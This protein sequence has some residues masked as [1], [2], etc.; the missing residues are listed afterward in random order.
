M[1]KGGKVCFHPGLT[2]TL[3]NENGGQI[4]FLKYCLQMV[5]VI[6]FWFFWIKITT[7]FK[8]SK[9]ISQRI[10]THWVTDMAMNGV[11]KSQSV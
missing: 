7:E 4:V 6:L 2:I 5:F 8:F 1:R 10:F 9:H 3:E 11:K